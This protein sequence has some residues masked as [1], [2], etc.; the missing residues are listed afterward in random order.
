MKN[1]LILLLL[2]YTNI[3]AA[4]NVVT[5]K[6]KSNEPLLGKGH[7]LVL[8]DIPIPTYPN[9]IGYFSTVDILG[10]NLKINK[11]LEKVTIKKGGEIIKEKSVIWD[12]YA[13]Q[14]EKIDLDGLIIELKWKSLNRQKME[15]MIYE[16]DLKEK[17]YELE[18][19]YKYPDKIETQVLKIEMPNFNSDIY[20]DFDYKN[21]I[22]KKQEYGKKY[23]IVKK[24]QLNDYNLEITKSE[25]KLDGLRLILK[26]EGVIEGDNQDTNYYRNTIKVVPLIEK[27]PGIFLEELDYGNIFKNSKEIFIGLELPKDLNYNKTYKISGDILSIAYKNKK[28]T[29]IDKIVI[30]SGE[31][32][33]FKI[34]GI[35]KNYNSQ[36]KIQIGDSEKNNK[37]YEVESSN[38]INK[39]YK[40]LK[41]KLNNIE[42]V[43]DNLGNS[44]V[45]LFENMK[46]KVENGKVFVSI[47]ELEKFEQGQ[48]ITYD[49]LNKN[50]EIIDKINLKFYM[51]N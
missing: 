43:I 45:I 29:L 30:L 38:S 7:Y 1:I 3:M 17:E 32:E 10:K 8:S 51:E 2:I 23:L 9:T 34:I 21:P 27:Y 49:I 28:N 13:F 4:K 24:I 44:R 33:I 5:L 40:N 37:Y 39:N 20:L 15:L 16:W 48:E 31:K 22:L 25:N 41:I 42:E 11:N 18:I 26:P 46:I 12:K 19:E 6:Y 35:T 50:N 36:D 14:M 47:D